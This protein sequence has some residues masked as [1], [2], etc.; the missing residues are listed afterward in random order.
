MTIQIPLIP[1]SPKAPL[2]DMES[3][4]LHPSWRNYFNELTIALQ[5]TLSNEGIPLPQ[6]STSNINLLTG[7][8]SIGAI[9]YDNT[10]NVAKI[11]LN[12]TWKTITTS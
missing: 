6:Q 2:L 8:Q 1:T 9:V 11:N 4:D 7:T 3:K 5:R 12:G 10:A